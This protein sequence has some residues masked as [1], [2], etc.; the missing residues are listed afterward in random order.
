MLP[1]TAWPLLCAGVKRQRR[2]AS[3]SVAVDAGQ[4]AAQKP[5]GAMVVVLDNPSG[6][7]EALLVKLK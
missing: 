4:V 3:V 2:T 5:L 1:G 7:S 6:T